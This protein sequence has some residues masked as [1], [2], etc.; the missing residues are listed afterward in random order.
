MRISLVAVGRYCNDPRARTL[1]RSLDSVGHEVTIVASG[2]GPDRIE[3]GLPVQFVPTR[4]PR[5]RGKVGQILRRVQP[6]SM[7]TRLHHRRLAA[8]V[9][10]TAPDIIYPVSEAAVKVA[11]MAA[12]GTKAT[13]V[14]DPRWQHAGPRDLIDLAPRNPDLSV[15][16]AG[17]GLPFLTPADKRPAY[18]PE[19]NR[20]AGMRIALCYRKTDT[21]PG[22]YLEAALIRA[23]IE[24]D[25]H[26][27]TFDWQKAH[28]ATDAVLF[29]EGPYPALK[30]LGENPGIPVL[31]WVHHGEH[32]IPTNLRLVE[33]YGAHAVLLAHSWHLA[34][35]FPVPVHRFTFGVAPELVD[36][37]VPW[38]E[39]KYAVSM[40]GGQLRRKGGTYA[41][42]QQLVDG[43]E[44]AFGKKETAFVSNV[45]A[46]EMARYYAHAKTVIN[47]GGTRHFPITMRV[48]E[49]VGS[50]AILITDDL[51]GTDLV[52]PREDYLVLESDVVTQVKRAL[53]DPARMAKMAQDALEFAMG[54]RTYD[55]C[56]D[57]LIEVTKTIDV[58]AATPAPP[59]KSAM[60]DLIDE[61]VEVQRLAQF[62]LPD[63]AAELPGREI[64][65]GEE[66]IDRLSPETV[67]GIVIGPGGANHLNRALQAARRYIYAAGEIAPIE[68]YVN[69]ELPDAT[70]TRHGELLRVDLNAESYRI[71]PHERSITT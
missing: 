8:A 36:P 58:P 14:R 70:C 30:V 3:D 62:G 47:E 40:V 60:A 1:A 46:Q 41:K 17:K 59:A 51:P 50:G 20:H 32:H 18:V 65:D 7:R 38:P 66:R 69:R 35:R 24:V 55:H 25:L 28:D 44:A 49:A 39:R 23:G 67:E 12:D 45:T 34:H 64:W 37:S 16:P 5:G 15:S 31:F 71:M 21:N 68:R 13:V 56:V 54:H 10:A 43:L 33:R 52:I 42:R 2:R 9:R 19:P 26:T 57:D 48:L 11:A 27:D 29:V 53:A 22:K 6:L 4:Y 61:D 63:L